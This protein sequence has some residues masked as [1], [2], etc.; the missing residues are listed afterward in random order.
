MSSSHRRYVLAELRSSESVYVDRL[1]VL[2]EDYLKYVQ[3]EPTVPTELKADVLAIFCNLHEIYEFHNKT[4]LPALEA[5]KEDDITAVMQCFLTH[6]SRF[7]VYMQYCKNKP[8]SDAARAEHDSF[9]RQRQSMLGQKLNIEDL[10]IA[11]VQ[12]FTKYQLLL[13]DLL[14][15][16]QKA[17]EDT[18]AIEEALQLM[19]HIPRET[20]NIMCMSLIRGVHRSKIVGHGSLCLQDTLLFWSDRAHGGVKAEPRQVFL[21]DHRIFV[22]LPANSDG[23]FDYQLDIKTLQGTLK[24]QVKSEPLRFSF[25]TADKSYFVFQAPSEASKREWLSAFNSILASQSQMTRALVFGKPVMPTKVPQGQPSL[26]VEWEDSDS[27]VDSVHSSP[28]SSTGDPDWPTSPGYE[29]LDSNE[30]SSFNTLTLPASISHSASFSTSRKLHK[31]RSM[32]WAA[33]LSPKLI[34]RFRRRP[35]IASQQPEHVVMPV[36]PPQRKGGLRSPGSAPRAFD[37]QIGPGA[38]LLVKGNVKVSGKEEI[39]FPGQLVTATDNSQGAEWTV[40]LLTGAGA[41]QNTSIPRHHLEAYS[42]PI[43]RQ[44]LS[45]THSVGRELG[46][47][48][49]S[50]V[51]KAKHKATGTYHAVKILRH[52]VREEAFEHELCMVFHLNHPNIACCFGGVVNSSERLLTFELV[53]GRNLFE[54]L[55]HKARVTDA[56]V[57]GLLRQ[58]LYALAYLHSRRI[59]HLDCRPTNLLVEECQHVETL[60]LIDFGAARHFGCSHQ[61]LPLEHSYE[62]PAGYHYL[63]PEA[64]QQQPVAAAADVWRN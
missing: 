26:S 6:K 5:C 11:P 13:Q 22:A 19:K 60:K 47:G 10:L 42:A 20:N 49:F 16:T 29:K 48:R 50:N 53:K 56:D 40:R 38:L 8:T 14:K 39:V 44:L 61:A 33:T 58:L 9:F 31:P 30:T 18:S 32:S 1:R 2:V 46:R 45:S 7:I 3:S 59:C 54:H 35:T 21:F 27:S 51:H 41:G 25:T 55:V 23:F 15:D 4:F 24:E 36:T 17:K 62:S 37:S 43:S 63:A 34:A 64:F 52:E 12:R 57:A 28:H